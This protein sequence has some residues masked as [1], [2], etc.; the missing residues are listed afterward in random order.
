MRQVANY[1]GAIRYVH[2]R[3]IGLI[4]RGFS[5]HEIRQRVRLPVRW[6]KLSYLQ[7]R[8]GRVEWAVSGIYRQY[9][10]WYDLNPAHLDPPAPRALARVVLDNGGSSRCLTAHAWQSRT[11]KSAWGSH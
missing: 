7:P 3:T 11:E 9:T 10:G 4:N 6:R 1:A 2:D 5:L 8:Y